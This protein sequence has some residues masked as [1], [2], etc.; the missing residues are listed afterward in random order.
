MSNTSAAVLTQSQF[1][2]AQGKIDN[3]ARSTRKGTPEQKTAFAALE[4]E[5]ESAVALPDRTVDQRA[6][7][8]A[9][10]ASVAAKHGLV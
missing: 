7:R 10:I 1:A 2:A 5:W 9:T 4:T 3:L 8:L 6:V